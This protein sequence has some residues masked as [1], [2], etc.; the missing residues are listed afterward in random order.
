MANSF[1]F[2]FKDLSAA[3]GGCLLDFMVMFLVNILIKTDTGVTGT[4]GRND[5]LVL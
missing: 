1:T 3:V 4:H 5:P 2:S